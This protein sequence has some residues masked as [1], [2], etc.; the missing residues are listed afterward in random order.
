MSLEITNASIHDLPAIYQLF[1]EAIQFQKLNNYIGWN[2]YDKQFI[3]SDVL[4]GLLYKIMDT[5]EIICIFSICYSDELIWRERERGDAIYLHRIVLNQ[6]FKGKKT[7]Q[8]ILDWAIRFAGERKRKY[9]RMDTW[10][11]N[12]KLIAYYKTYGFT[13]I[14]NH[15]TPGTENLPVQHRNLRIALLEKTIN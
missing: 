15:T 14:E 2:S 4:N 3:Q 13:F 11:D 5:R 10:A 6:K 9:I 12:E 7:F 1:E 8:K